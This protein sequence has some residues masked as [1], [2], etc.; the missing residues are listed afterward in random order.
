MAMTTDC[1]NTET[2]I[3][4]IQGYL[5][6]V[7]NYIAM[8]CSYWFGKNKKKYQNTHTHTYIHTYI[9][10]YICLMMNVVELVSPCQV[11]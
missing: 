6:E 1:V 8:I 3:L 2:I 9:Y 5:K 11:H 10:I 4:L 7:R